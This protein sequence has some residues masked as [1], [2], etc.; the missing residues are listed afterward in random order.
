MCQ[1]GRTRAGRVE[2]GRGRQPGNHLHKA[3]ALAA[4]AAEVHGREMCRIPEIHTCWI[5]E[6]G[7]HDTDD[8]GLLRAKADR[9]AEHV[10]VG[11]K[12]RAPKVVAE[13]KGKPGA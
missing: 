12:G 13:H 8:G 11:A 9:T 2:S 5:S 3:G 10:R 4:V 1:N 7:G 6:A